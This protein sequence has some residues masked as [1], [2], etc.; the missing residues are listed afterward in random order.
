MLHLYLFTDSDIGIRPQFLQNS[1]EVM[2]SST[3]PPDE[4]EIQESTIR[5]SPTED[6]S[7]T[8]TV[9][10]PRNRATAAAIASLNVFRR[11]NFGMIQ[12]D[13]CS[14]LLAD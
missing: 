7:Y 2:S 14:N 13:Q 11:L 10:G 9:T 6:T 4:N 3:V 12:F 5:V 1:V 8:C